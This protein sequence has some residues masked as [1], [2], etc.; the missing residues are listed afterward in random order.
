MWVNLGSYLLGE[1]KPGNVCINAFRFCLWVDLSVCSSLPVP[2]QSVQQSVRLQPAVPVPQHHLLL[3]TE[4]HS[5]LLPLALT[6]S[7][8]GHPGRSLAS[9]FSH[10]L[11]AK[12]A[13]DFLPHIFFCFKLKLRYRKT[14]TKKTMLLA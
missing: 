8:H 14:L 6:L 9:S 3:L 11:P 7:Q 1:N 4:A 12:L 10:T 2:Y 5:Q 13:S